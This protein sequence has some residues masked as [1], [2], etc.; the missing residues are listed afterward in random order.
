VVLLG[1][2]LG[3]ACPFA[4]DNM[5]STSLKLSSLERSKGDFPL[6]SLLGEREKERER[7]RERVSESE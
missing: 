1:L 5:L 6:S 3:L 7:E 4:A 2:G